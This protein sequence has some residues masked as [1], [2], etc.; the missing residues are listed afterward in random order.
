[1][2]QD[3]IRRL[4]TPNN[5]HKLILQGFARN[6]VEHSNETMSR[7]SIALL[8]T[9]F[10]SA[11]AFMVAPSFRTVSF[12]TPSRL[13][14]TESHSSLNGFALPYHDHRRLALKLDS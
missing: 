8:L 11:Q 9:L 7:F 13:L 1:M 10:A 6:I 3:S 4:R 5:S 14:R 2:I 12:S